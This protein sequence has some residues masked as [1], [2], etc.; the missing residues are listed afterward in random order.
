M[1]PWL[2]EI[3]SLGLQ[4]KVSGGKPRVNI[5]RLL[6]IKGAVCLLREYWFCYWGRVWWYQHTAMP[7]REKINLDWMISQLNRDQQ[8]V[9]NKT[10]Y[11]HFGIWQWQFFL[12]WKQTITDVCLWTSRKFSNTDSFHI[13]SVADVICPTCVAVYNIMYYYCHIF[14]WC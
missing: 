2:C 13:Y 8:G 7:C 12:R 9:Y 6:K 11:T 4:I 14:L 3:E 1:K 5:C 10:I